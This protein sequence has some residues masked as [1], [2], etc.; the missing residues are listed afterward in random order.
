MQ[1][2]FFVPSFLLNFVVKFLT[3][4]NMESLRQ[5]WEKCL[6]VI[7]DNV[8]E[9]NFDTLFKGLQPISLEKNTLQLQAPTYFIVEYIEGNFLDLMRMALRKEFGA[10]VKLEWITSV[11][12]V[13]TN[14]IP[15]QETVAPINKPVPMMMPAGKFN[16]F[17]A[18]GLR[19]LEIDPQ[20][21]PKYS[22]ENYIEGECNRLA[23]AAGFAIAKNPGRAE[24]SPLFIH[25]G[26]GLGKTHL[27]HAIG[28]ETKKMHP[29]KTVLYLSAHKFQEQYTTANIKKEINNFLNFY[30]MIDVLI[31]DD[32]HDFAK[33]P[34]TQNTFFQIFEHLYR[35]HKQLIFTSDTAPA[36]LKEFEPRI[37]SRFKWGLTA[38]LTPPDYD[39]RLAIFKHKVY[40]NGLNISEE[41]I[42]YLAGKITSSV[43][44]F[45]GVLNTIMA[46]TTFNKKPLTLDLIKGIVNKNVKIEKKEY[47]IEE[48]YRIVC[49]YYNLTPDMAQSS[50]RKR[51]IV[52]VRQMAMYFC[53]EFTNSSLALIGSRI[54]GKNHAT[55][56]HACKIISEQKE[57]DRILG[58]TINNIEKRIKL[59]IA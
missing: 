41:I 12:G 44:E 4:Y 19:S 59:G 38:E 47:S 14:P 40:K 23:R 21:N 20:L 37:L 54:G 58:E 32:V 13:P 53:K 31:L 9:S 39:T 43:R 42:E 24:F 57:L 7:A 52:H 11:N 45:E 3:P 25:G 49:N 16:P 8:T 17:V 48:I 26:T 36:D 55:V 6:Q 2:N 30:Q 27:A 34:G 28:L 35:L 56:L 5:T 10:A 1:Q 46:E 29:Q 50:S 51:E 22:F 33:K 18:P 15:T